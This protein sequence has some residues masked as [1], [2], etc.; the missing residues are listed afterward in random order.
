M[1]LQ[2]LNLERV[3]KLLS[4]GRANSAI[5]DLIVSCVAS[6]SL[7]SLTRGCAGKGILGRVLAECLQAPAIFVERR[8]VFGS[9]TFDNPDD[10]SGSDDKA[11]AQSYSNTRICL[12]VASLE[13][14][15]LF[16]AHAPPTSGV[17]VCAKHLCGQGTDSAFDCI[18]RARSWPY[19]AGIAIAPCCHQTIPWNAL[20]EP[21]QRWFVDRGFQPS[22]WPLLKLLL[23]LSK[24]GKPSASFSSFP[25]LSDIPPLRLHAM[26]RLARRCIEEARCFRLN[27][28][29]FSTTLFRYSPAAVTPDN[30]VIVAQP[31]QASTAMHSR[32]RGAVCPRNVAQAPGVIIRLECS[33]RAGSVVCRLYESKHA[34]LSAKA[35]DAE[36]FCVA[37]EQT[38]Y[39]PHPLPSSTV[40]LKYPEQALAQGIT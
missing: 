24:S 30:L 23:H 5:I 27:G 18:E 31:F 9:H 6:L 2:W 15:A 21:C 35:C 29:G 8:D 1:V 39:V 3:S 13:L 34:Q 17:L 14:P 16:E 22:W 20:P 26:G 4:Y 19:L 28:L 37:W 25:T 38:L 33:E 12:D 10:R 36:L 7:V 11:A 40:F 32:L